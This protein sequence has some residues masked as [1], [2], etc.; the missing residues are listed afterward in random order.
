MSQ[1]RTKAWEPSQ[2]RASSTLGRQAEH[3]VPSVLGIALVLLPSERFV[4]SST[5]RMGALPAPKAYAMPSTFGKQVEGKNVSEPRTAFGTAY[6][7]NS[8]S[9]QHE[10]TRSAGF[11][12]LERWGPRVKAELG[13]PAV[14]GAYS[15]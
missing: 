6:F 9:R 14:P 10:L 4:H 2:M 8:H 7:S 12:K 13:S 11:S 5:A 1:D 15:S 3:N